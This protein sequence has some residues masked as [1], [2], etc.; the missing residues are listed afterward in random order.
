LFGKSPADFEALQAEFMVLVKAWD[1]TFGQTVHQRFS[2]RF[3]EVVWGGRFTPAFGVDEKGDLQ[4]HVDKVGNHV[5]ENAQ[6]PSP[7]RLA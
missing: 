4:V 3:N 1:E 2:Y 5:I 6:L 7:I